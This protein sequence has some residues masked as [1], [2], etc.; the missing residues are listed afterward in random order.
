M[1]GFHKI[2]YQN[3]VKTLKQNVQTAQTYIRIII[4][5]VDE[6]LSDLIEN[7]CGK[8]CWMFQHFSS[9]QA[10]VANAMFRLSI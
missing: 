7:K 8:V 3:I 2:L 9:V 4:I 6:Q 5:M 10:T 1:H